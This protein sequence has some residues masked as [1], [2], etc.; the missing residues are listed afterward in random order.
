MLVGMSRL[1]HGIEG[2]VLKRQAL[3]ILSQYYSG[4]KMI[5]L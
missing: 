4:D 5:A 3:I 2:Q 1:P